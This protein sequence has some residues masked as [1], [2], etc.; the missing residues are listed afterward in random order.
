MSLD[1]AVLTAV[2]TGYLFLGSM[3]KD[4][5]LEKFIGEPYRNYERNVVGFP[6][7][8]RGPLGKRR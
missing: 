3:I 4:R 1:H 5:R 6:L 7:M 2:W 8:A